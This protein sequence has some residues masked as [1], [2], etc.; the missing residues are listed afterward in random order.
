MSSTPFKTGETALQDIAH[1]IALV[2]TFLGTMSFAEFAGDIKTVY[3]SVRCL[4]ILSEASRRLP[5]DLKER[6]PAIDWRRMAS[7]GNVYRHD[8]EDVEARQVWKTV[9]E[10]LPPLRQA[11]EAEIAKLV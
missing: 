1:H 5:A 8:Y 9:A 6:H 11:I 10:A 7:A 2:R 3:A 4:E